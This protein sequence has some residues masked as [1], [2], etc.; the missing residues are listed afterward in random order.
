MTNE[1]LFHTV[2]ERL[3]QEQMYYWTL[4]E[5]GKL[6]DDIYFG[7]ANHDDCE[8]S[9]GNECNRFIKPPTQYVGF[10]HGYDI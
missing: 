4:Q 7:S 1:T 10:E 5:L 8:I 9:V 6:T 2:R 3:E